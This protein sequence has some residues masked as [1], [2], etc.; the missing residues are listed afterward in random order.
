MSKTVIAVIGCA[1][2]AV[3]MFA[4]QTQSGLTAP[5]PPERTKWE[6]K[7]LYENGV[8][9]HSLPKIDHVE[10]RWVTEELA[11]KLNKLGD[12]GWQLAGVQKPEG[13]QPTIFILK[14]SK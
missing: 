9:E 12:E 6:Y 2:F 13:Q 1:V 3:A 7:V 4:L 8:G 5:A 11:A 10:G 14:R